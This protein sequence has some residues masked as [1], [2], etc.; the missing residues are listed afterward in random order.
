MSKKPEPDELSLVA[1]S[2]VEPKRA[3]RLN[4]AARAPSK[5]KPAATRSGNKAFVAVEDVL[6]AS[7]G[8]RV[9]T[10]LFTDAEIERLATI[11]GLSGE[12]VAEL[13]RPADL[14]PAAA[15]AP[16]RRRARSTRAG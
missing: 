3:A 13:Y 12:E 9:L 11:F 5:A 10:G 16:L 14:K 6:I 8:K 15:G 7:M 1:A 2:S 4:V